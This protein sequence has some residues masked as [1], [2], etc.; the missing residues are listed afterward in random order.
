M[1]HCIK[2]GLSF[3]LISAV[4]TTLG[5]MVG[6]HSST[7]SKIIVIGGILLIA[8]ADAFSDAMGIHFSEES[9]NVHSAKEIWV[10]TVFTFICKFS[11]ILA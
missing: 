1:N 3:G 7:H 2:V 10:S 4:I 11:I 8:I 9:E 5:L 6:L